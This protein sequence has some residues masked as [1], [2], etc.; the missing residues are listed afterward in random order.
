VGD[1]ED[2]WKKRPEYARRAMAQT[3][4]I[5]RACRS[6]F[7]FVVVLIDESLSTTPA[8]EMEG[9]AHV[10]E[11]VAA[12]DKAAAIKATLA[13]AARVAPPASPPRAPSGGVT[14]L[15]NYGKA[16]GQPIATA[17]SKTL[18]YYRAGAMRS[19]ED[20]SKSKWHD[21]ERALLEAIDAELSRRDATVPTDDGPPPH[22]DADQPL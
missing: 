8:E 22:T 12:T 7:A 9:V 19:L 16:K 13:A 1:D 2:T 10:V 14:T 18:E 17:D 21:R 20:A 4:A 5:S 6:A 15:P 3:R 11:S